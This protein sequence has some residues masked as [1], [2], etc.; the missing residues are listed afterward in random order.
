VETL[1]ELAGA[2][3]STFSERFTALVGSSPARYV[4]R[5]RVHVAGR[6][7]RTEQLTVAEAALR[8]GYES[9]AVFSRAF[10]R[11]VG[12]PP[13]TLRQAKARERQAA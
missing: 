13:S 9:D 6:W 11:V 1:A 4:A 12:V 2:S 7:L 5:W 8:L 10:K 3:R